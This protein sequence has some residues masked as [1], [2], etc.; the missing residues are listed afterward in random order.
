MRRTLAATGLALA[1]VGLGP[2]PLVALAS[3]TRAAS[4]VV[5]ATGVESRAVASPEPL[6]DALRDPDAFARARRL[7]TLLPTLGAET[8]PEVR[9]E[10]EN[11]AIDRGAVEIVLLVRFWAAHDPAGAA[12]WALTRAPLG[13]REAAALPSVELWAKADPEGALEW[14]RGLRVRPGPNSEVIQI[15]LV[16]GWFDSGRPGLEDYVRGLGPSFEQQLALGALSRKTIQRDGP[17]AA[18]RWAAALPDE[19]RSFKLAA[20]RQ[21]GSELA[22]ADPTAAVAWCAARC[23]G[24]F[25]ANLR[26]MIA[27]RWAVQ[28]APATM[29][30]IAAAAPGEERDRAVRAALRSWLRKDREE[31]L[32]WVEAKGLEGVEPWLRPALDLY[33][34][35]ISWERPD[36]AVR[37]ALLIEDDARRQ[38]ALVTIA[39][40]WRERDEASADAW[41]EQSPLSADARERA[42]TPTRGRERPPRRPGP[43]TGPSDAGP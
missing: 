42:R 17:N 21:L 41:L 36:E 13:F 2:H 43:R 31:A 40:R 6:L 12:R 39:R 33:A 14:M 28:D 23:D 19:P 9:R 38:S 26:Q 32:A 20:F 22:Q 30:W 4:P 7:A 35:P 27:T 10:L 3:D 18:M 1:A 11:P 34:V 8:V 37:W 24:P 5:S 15:A 25:G 29:E 16:R